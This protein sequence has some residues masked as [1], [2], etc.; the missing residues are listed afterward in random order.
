MLL[1][2]DYY[3]EGSGMIGTISS[4]FHVSTCYIPFIVGALVVLTYYPFLVRAIFL[5]EFIIQNNMSENQNE[6]KN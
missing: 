2:S 3:V 6:D 5:V 1:G 4:K